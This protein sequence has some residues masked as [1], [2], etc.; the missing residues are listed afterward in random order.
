MQTSEM[1]SPA[2]RD[3]GNR[4][5]GIDGGG[6]RVDQQ[7]NQLTDKSQALRGCVWTVSAD[8]IVIAFA[9]ADRVVT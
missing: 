2:P 4:A 7:D 1:E 3:I 6:R 8:L 5:E 9:A